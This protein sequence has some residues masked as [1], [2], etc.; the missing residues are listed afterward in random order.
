[1]NAFKIWE[2]NM[3]PLVIKHSNEVSQPPQRLLDIQ[4]CGF[5]IAIVDYQRV[6]TIH[7]WGV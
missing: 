4:T 3:Y 5:S 2:E 7:F 1:M 6:E